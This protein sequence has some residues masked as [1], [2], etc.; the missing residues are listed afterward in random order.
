MAAAAVEADPQQ[1]V[2][3]F[4]KLRI[5]RGDKSPTAQTIITGF[6]SN[7]LKFDCL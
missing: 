5:A 2:Q 6:C 1:L 4:V 3:S 7:I